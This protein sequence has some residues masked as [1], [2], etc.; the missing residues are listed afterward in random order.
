MNLIRL[1][2]NGRKTY[3]DKH[4]GITWEPGDTN[5]VTHETAKKLL[6]FAEF[7][8]AEQEAERAK[9][10]AKG[11]KDEEGEKP[12]DTLDPEVE[13]ALLREQEAERAKDQERKQLESMLLTVES[14][15]KSALEAYAR[16]YEVELDKRLAVG[17]L[18]ADVANLVEQFGVR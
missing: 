4:M 17:K 7:A 18:R 3:R 9:K 13:A 6:R 11:K 1:A 12:D 5:L 10:P 15:D 16:K 14:M 2:Y 8:H